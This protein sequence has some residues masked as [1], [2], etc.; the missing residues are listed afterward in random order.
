MGISRRTQKIVDRH[1]DDVKCYERAQKFGMPEEAEKWYQRAK[2]SSREAVESDRQ[3][4]VDRERQQREEEQRQR[5][6]R[7]RGFNWFGN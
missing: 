7:G 3:D 4:Q 6:K 5:E 1:R 2:A